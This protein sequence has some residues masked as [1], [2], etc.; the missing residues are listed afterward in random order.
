MVFDA[1]D[2]KPFITT[3]SKHYNPYNNMEKPHSFH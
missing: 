1:E 3:N 2:P